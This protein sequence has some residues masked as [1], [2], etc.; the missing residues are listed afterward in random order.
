MKKISYAILSKD[1]HDTVLCKCNNWLLA[2]S[3]FTWVRECLLD[4]F[5]YLQPLAL[6]SDEIK[7]IQRLWPDA[8]FVP[9]YKNSNQ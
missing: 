5:T 6:H 1:G 7:L 4:K 9:Y 3:P 8:K 2:D